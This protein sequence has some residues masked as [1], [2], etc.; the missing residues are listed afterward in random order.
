MNYNARFERTFSAAHR[1]WNDDSPCRNIHGHNFRVSVTVET[2][3]LT[4]Q[5]FTVPHSAVKAVNDSFDH[6]LILD[7]ADPLRIEDVE[8]VLV[9]GPPSTERL[10][11]VIAERIAGAARAS[12][13]GAGWIEVYV[14]LKETDAI[15]ADAYASAGS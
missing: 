2:R 15:S 8:I 9:R 12:N 5:G 10:A 6:R 14:L 7:R 4:K 13:P 11:Y 1:I 3:G